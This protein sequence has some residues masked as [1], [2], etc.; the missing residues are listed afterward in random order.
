MRMLCVV[1]DILRQIH[2]AHVQHRRSAVKPA[3]LHVNLSDYHC[4]NVIHQPLS[5]LLQMESHRQQAHDC[6]IG[7]RYALC[8]ACQSQHGLIE[9]VS[10]KQSKFKLIAGFVR[11]CRFCL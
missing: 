9:N 11:N 1:C 7:R 5:S 8:H 6:H 4:A 2:G 10:C 3:S